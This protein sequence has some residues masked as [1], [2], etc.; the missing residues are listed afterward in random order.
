MSD[1]TLQARNHALAGK[2][3]AKLSISGAD[4][5]QKMRKVGRRLPRRLR[6]EGAYLV[7]AAQMETHPQLSR[8][9]DFPR[10]SRAYQDFD[11]Y[12]DKIDPGDLLWGR[13][14]D[15]LGEVAFNILIFA[16]ILIALFA[17]RGQLGFG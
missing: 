3:A 17:M 8:Q 7:Q 14:L 16:A 10:V 1:S 5:P 2:L 9:I 11:R 15:I 4:L 12:L 13:I 6:R